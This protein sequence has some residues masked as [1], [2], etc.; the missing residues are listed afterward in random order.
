MLGQQRVDAVLERRAHLG[1]RHSVSQQIA[2]VTQLT[3]RNVGLGQQIRAQQ[4]G[5]RAGVDGVGPNPRRGDRARPERMREVQL[6]AGF[7]EQLS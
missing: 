6:I 5:E 7:L 4:L 2:Q 3:R 1:E